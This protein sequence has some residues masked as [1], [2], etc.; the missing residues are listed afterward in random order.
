M[1]SA[2]LR[3][4]KVSSA[5]RFS[6]SRRALAQPRF[7]LATM[8][9]A[10]GGATFW[11][12]A[13]TGR[14]P[15]AMKSPSAAATASPAAS[16]SK[17]TLANLPAMMEAYGQ[18]R[19]RT[20]S[21]RA[22]ASAARI[23]SAQ[24]GPRPGVA[25]AIGDG[26]T[27]FNLVETDLTPGT[28][29]DDIE[30]T[31]SPS[32]D[33]IA[34]VSNRVAGGAAGA[35][36]HL[37]LMN[38]DGSN[39]R[40]ITGLSTRDQNINQRRPSWSPDGNQLAYINGDGD[41]SQL[42]I[43]DVFI[44][45][46]NDTANGINPP[47]RQRTFRL[48][49]KR[50]PAWSPSGLAI[51]FATNTNPLT[52]S[53]TQVGTRLGSFDLYSISPSGSDIS[54][55]RLTGQDALG[56]QT[57]EFNP[58]YSLVNQSVIF[59]S[60]NRDGNSNTPLENGR[61]IW[62]VN[63]NGNGLFQVTDPT[64]RGTQNSERPAIVDD[65]PASSLSNSGGEQ[66]AF[67]SNA[68]IDTTDAG[69]EGAADNN[70]WSLPV[71]SSDLFN[72]GVVTSEG[73]PLAYVSSFFGNELVALR[74]DTDFVAGASATPPVTQSEEATDQF[75]AVPVSRPEG[76][77]LDGG[78]V[79]VSNRTNGRVDR[80]DANTGETIPGSNFGQSFTANSSVPS[81]SDILIVGNFLY[82][83]SGGSTTA[84][85][86]FSLGDGGIF[87]GGEPAPAVANATTAA[88]SSGKTDVGNS[89]GL[90]LGPDGNLYVSEF[91][92]NRIDVYNR[93]T[94]VFIRT[95]AQ[96]ST[97]APIVPLN[98]PTD[99][100]FVSDQNDDG[101]EDVAVASSIGDD[102]ILLS[103]P[104]AAATGEKARGSFISYIVQDNNGATSGLNAPE[105][106]VYNEDAVDANGN[107][108]EAIYVSSLYAP[109]TAT[110]SGNSVLRFNL[111]DSTPRPAAGKTGAIFLQSSRLQGPGY[112]A[113]NEA[114]LANSATPPVVATANTEFSGDP[115]SVARLVTNIISSPKNF[116]ASDL[117]KSTPNNVK[118]DKAPDVHPTYSRSTATPQLQSRLIFA[119]RRAFA[120]NPESNTADATPSNTAPRNAD[121]TADTHDIWSTSTFDRT[122]PILIPQGAGNVLS[123]VVAPGPDSPFPAPRTFEA[124]LRPDDDNPATTN[125]IV[126]LAV[127]LREL[128]SGIPVFDPTKPDNQ[129]VVAVTA[130]F[131]QAGREQFNSETSK[132]NADILVRVARERKGMAVPN[133]VDLP[134]KV[135]DNGSPSVGG[136]ELQ[137]EAVAG[138]GIYYCAG[139]LPAPRSAGDFYI[140]IEV[141]D[142]AASPNTFVYDN[143][144][145]FSTEEFVKSASLNDLFVSDYTAGQ[146]FPARLTS[147]TGGFTD[148]R[149]SL[150]PPVESYYL[151][152]PG[153]IILSRPSA[154]DSDRVTLEQVDVWRILS[155][156]AVPSQILDAYRPTLVNQIDPKDK[157]GDFI[158]QTRSVPLSNNAVIWGAPY[159]RTT[160]AG[161]GSITD[162]DVQLTLT[163][164]LQNGGRL[165]L[166]G[167]EIL[168]G[169]T[170]EG[171]APNGFARDELAANFAGET[172]TNNLTTT[173]TFQDN[174]EIPFQASDTASFAD[175]AGN[176]NPGSGPAA[177]MDIISP[178]GT[179]NKT[180]YTAGDSVVGQSI[181]RTRANNSFESRVVFLSFGLEAVNRH[182]RKYDNNTSYPW[183]VRKRMTN[184]IR[185]F[186]K[187]GGV[188]GTVI[189]DATN[190]PIAN[191]LVEVRGTGG[192]YFART[193]ANGTFNI[194]GLPQGGYSIGPA[195]N[196]KGE[197]IND[198][199]LKGT[200]RGF[201]VNLNIPA[202]PSRGFPNVPNSDFESVNFR[203]VPIVPGSLTGTA[204]FDA[205]T[206][207]SN[208][209]VLI[210]SIQDDVP[211][212][213]EQFAQ[214]TR[215][216]ADGRFAFNNV[217]ST[218]GRTKINYKVIFNPTVNDIP[219]DSG[220]RTNYQNNGRGGPDL[221]IGRRVVPDEDDKYGRSGAIVIPTGDNFVLNDQP[222]DAAGE[223]GDEVKV[224]RGP[225]VMGSVTLTGVDSAG[226]ARVIDF[227]GAVVDLL[228]GSN[229][230]G[231]DTTDANGKYLIENIQNNEDKNGDGTRDP[232]YRLRFSGTIQGAVVPPVFVE[233][234]AVPRQS[235]PVNI[236]RQLLSIARIS[237]RVTINGDETSG[238]QV[239]LLDSSGK[240]VQFGAADPKFGRTDV[241]DIDGEYLLPYVPAGNYKVQVSFGGQTRTKDVPVPG[242]SDVR[243]EDFALFQ[244][245]LTGSVT[246]QTAGSGVKTALPGAIVEVLNSSGNSLNPKVTATTD[247]RGMYR[248]SGI[249]RGSYRVRAS[250]KGDDITSATFAVVDGATTAPALTIV[251]HD[252]SVRVVD[253]R[254]APVNTA[255][256]ELRQGDGRL[257]SGSTN[258]DGVFVF[259]QIA[260]GNYSVLVTKGNLGGQADVTITRGRRP[261]V[262]TITLQ[263]DSTGDSNPTAF[264][265]KGKIYL[266]SIPYQ[267]SNNPTTS[268]VSERT[269]GVSPATTK[270]KNAFTV[271]PVDPATGRQNYLL[272]RFNPLTRAYET[273]DGEANLVRGVGYLL[274][275]INQGTSI[276]MPAQD[277]SRVAL[278]DRR[279]EKLFT[280]T[281]HLNPSARD[282]RNNGR[283]LI[284]FGFNPA[285]FGT[286]EFKTAK[287]THPDGRT[288][289]SIDQAVANGWMRDQ[290]TTID[291][292]G[293]TP[294]TINAA[295][296]KS[297][298]GY[299]VQTRVDGLKISF[300]NPTR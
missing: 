114:A 117:N 283:N 216:D 61:R 238:V 10:V 189:N 135:Y 35:N 138:D 65:Y 194:L 201:S 284:G 260:A 50:T 121:G 186:F 191:F 42:Y 166:S 277:S 49:D 123:P 248:L 74:T 200:E 242:T 151:N 246:L 291:S 105:G 150:M 289:E 142:R 83:A 212:G 234:V 295:Q 218:V 27:G 171:T 55:V 232:V 257:Q 197:P 16:A 11:A 108:F 299:F 261:S 293:T 192:L 41:S 254:R 59:F 275:V 113:L 162:P 270:V 244:Q 180:L 249:A 161:P 29:S 285:R 223:S 36:Y 280:V 107:T 251:L 72:A 184:E 250:F 12:T 217:P 18:A 37:W 56:A 97:T 220:L 69:T 52:G 132:V 168:F 34:F 70:I 225:D 153:G 182:Y 287:V 259:K 236:P 48:G 71:N 263:G 103:G 145:G 85:Y 109:N 24:G 67:Q 25:A 26:S 124:G 211:A 8:A 222:N 129:Q 154:G 177:M 104:E 106:L 221:N 87:N 230:I 3:V 160:F 208:V 213:F 170:S 66:L 269:A 209:D 75:P 203:A 195:E 76:V 271:P 290:I 14:A 273:L 110:D 255:F 147:A 58:A 210:V 47:I 63:S 23:A 102:V 32:G 274:Q 33:F 88:F 141:R 22:A 256:V 190:A 196:E 155:R 17:S 20:A 40:Q 252:L 30:P 206:P 73:D 300:R 112:F 44:D 116:A 81:P 91:S 111:E 95:F 226:N 158:Q 133:R 15:V 125:D 239:V 235:E 152:N 262:L 173:G 167:R 46:D 199:F 288:A 214:I 99:L 21:E 126:K 7:L 282:D 13:Q 292:R 165:L 39:P 156:G 204:V 120:A 28:A 266:L 130:S 51:T 127:V 139:D 131:Y 245:L 149:F 137:A 205:T 146:M 237:G 163:N 43:A 4:S 279:F 164:Y 272:Q 122:P 79:Y 296:L 298:G 278:T 92:K 188:S 268:N 265:V 193:N 6:R 157:T 267:D 176:Q 77:V 38:R 243:V 64:R 143:I 84:I 98:G 100:V 82:V 115:R 227:E 175:A 118:Q 89:E 247:S 181:I 62:K 215:T 60:T 264:N 241:T 219:R 45:S 86:R 5:L 94:G 19:V 68:F 286:V 187:T 202:V 140:D 53:A 178:Q 231:T 258:A 253:A 93:N 294:R 148:P 78:Y 2:S 31:F 276:K 281:L 169:L 119:S 233:N 229:V 144:Y 54:V 224:P 9:L 128:E 90:A 159:A 101:F 228:S 80:F 240:P 185:R 179:F 174:L 134:L 207:A 297:F 57:D 136:N 96:G 1:K 198:G 183:N 172:A